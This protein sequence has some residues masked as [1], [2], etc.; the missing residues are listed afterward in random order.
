MHV[1]YAMQYLHRRGTQYPF[2]IFLYP[3]LHLHF[4]SKHT[5]CCLHLHSSRKLVRQSTW[6]SYLFRN[7]ENFGAS[8]EDEDICLSPQ[9]REIIDL[10]ATDKSRYFAQHGPIIIHCFKYP[11]HSIGQFRCFKILTWLRGLGE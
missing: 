7:K 9:L 8:L 5:S 6:F 11:S 2:V 3:S 1:P 4:P 10:L